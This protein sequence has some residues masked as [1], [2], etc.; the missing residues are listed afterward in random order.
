[1][2]SGHK[3][4]IY[5]Y[6]VILQ[7]SCFHK[8]IDSFVSVSSPSHNLEVMVLECGIDM[9]IMKILLWKGK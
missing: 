7:M 8:T 3:S 6:V 5:M 2:I 9:E 1:V 4:T